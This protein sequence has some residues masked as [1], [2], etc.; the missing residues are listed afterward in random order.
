MFFRVPFLVQLLF[1]RRI[2]RGEDSNSVYLTFDDGPDIETTPWVLDL[3][4]RE[5]IKA[6]FFCIGQ[7]IEKH[8][9]LFKEIL[10]NGHRIGNHTYKHEKGTKTRKTA[11][12]D[13][14]G[15]TETLHSSNLFRPPYGRIN[16]FQVDNLLSMGKKIIMWTWNAQDY[17]KS[18]KHSQIIDKARTIRG[19]DILL[20][21]NSKKSEHNMKNSLPEVIK[22]VKQ[23]ELLFKL[24]D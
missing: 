20:F 10:N 12:L 17:K 24:L 8:P 6:T 21:H 18:L 5:N 2:W 22:I 3:L 15:K 14:I 11:Y 23:K 7:N 4:K 1:K 19:R 13:S 9:S 16:I